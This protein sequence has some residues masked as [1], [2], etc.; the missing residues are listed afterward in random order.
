MAGL[1][2]EGRNRT[3][4]FMRKYSNFERTGLEAAF[5]YTVEADLKYSFSSSQKSTQINH[6]P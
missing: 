4:C 2:I 6:G 1:D 5:R 3:I